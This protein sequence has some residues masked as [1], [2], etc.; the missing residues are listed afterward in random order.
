MNEGKNHILQ[1][2]KLIHNNPTIITMHKHVCQTLPPELTLSLADS[3]RYRHL[4]TVCQF[5]YS[6]IETKKSG[7]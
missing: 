4:I 5:V 1:I 6:D 2:T 3:S 7:L